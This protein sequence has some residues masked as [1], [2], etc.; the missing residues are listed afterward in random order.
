MVELSY[1]GPHS[2]CLACPLWWSLP[3]SLLV[4][5]SQ[6]SAGTSLHTQALPSLVPAHTSCSPRPT[7][8]RLCPGSVRGVSPLPV[9]WDVSLSPPP[10][11]SLSLRLSLCYNQPSAAGGQVCLTSLHSFRRF[12]VSSWACVFFL[13]ILDEVTCFL[14]NL[15]ENVVESIFIDQF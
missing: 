9:V 5:V 12:L 1:S 2:C 3:P 13:H 15:Y 11:A 4:P 7:G 14:E 8:P 6:F 10:S